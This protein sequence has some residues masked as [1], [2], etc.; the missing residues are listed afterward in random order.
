MAFLCK[1][2]L[3]SSL[4]RKV[5]NNPLPTVCS[6][7]FMRIDPDDELENLQVRGTFSEKVKQHQQEECLP[8]VVGYP[9]SE[10]QS[11]LS[12]TSTR[13]TRAKSKFSSCAKFDG[14]VKIP[15]GEVQEAYSKKQSSGQALDILKHYNIFTDLFQDN[16]IFYPNPDLGFKVAY[17]LNEE[18]VLPVF[19][20]NFIA[21]ED[22]SGPP[23][24]S[25]DGKEDKS[26]SVLMINLD[27]HLSDDRGEYLHWSCCK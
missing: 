1:N 23:L 8:K 13:A 17:S 15:L 12:T 6:K 14:L 24:V 20:G 7:R 26:Y 4:V 27:G 5:A 3:R 16:V 10:I 18:E 21:A 19:R 22:T 11:Q 2:V 25:Y 9:L